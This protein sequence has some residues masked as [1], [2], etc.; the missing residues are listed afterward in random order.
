MINVCG[1][2]LREFVIRVSEIGTDVT[3]VPIC[4]DEKDG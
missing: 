1:I 2:K 4:Q 3:A